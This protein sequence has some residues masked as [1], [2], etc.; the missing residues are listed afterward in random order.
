ME[1]QNQ[2][3]KDECLIYTDPFEH[4]AKIYDLTSRYVPYD[5]WANFIFD[6]LKRHSKLKNRIV[7]ELSAG[8]GSFRTYFNLPQSNIIFV[9]IFRL[10]C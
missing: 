6:I 3:E 9:L 1:Y 8:T 5:M 7:L 2:T 10:L 4:S